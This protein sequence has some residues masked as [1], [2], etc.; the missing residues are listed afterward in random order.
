M[1]F[2]LID[3]G[4]YQVSWRG[5][6]K[7]AYDYVL[8]IHSDGG[9][10]FMPELRFRGFAY[11]L[12]EYVLVSHQ[13]ITMTADR[14]GFL[15]SQLSESIKAQATRDNIDVGI[16]VNHR[17]NNYPERGFIGS[18]IIEYYNPNNDQDHITLVVY[19]GGNSDRFGVL[20]IVVTDD[21]DQR[22][23][24][25]VDYANE[26]ISTNSNTL[27]NIGEAPVEFQPEPI[28]GE[29]DELIDS[30]QEIEIKTSLEPVQL[31]LIGDNKI[32]LRVDNI[33]QDDVY[34][35]R[36]ILMRRIDGDANLEW[37]F[38]TITD[39]DYDSEAFDFEYGSL[40]VGTYQIM[41]YALDSD[42]RPHKS[43]SIIWNYG[44]PD[45]S[46]PVDYTDVTGTDLPIK[47]LDNFL[48]DRTKIEGFSILFGHP[49]LGVNSP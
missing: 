31:D 35:D 4:T 32:R 39:L 16:R 34:K 41:Q 25:M 5:R 46:S 1:P 42:N 2:T 27:R 22:W 47:D 29:S 40:E 38:I 6:S 26:L 13:P 18:V 3:R 20:D 30:M 17:T 9:I 11:E 43:P 37:G 10:F 45:T 7:E 15:G 19:L 33:P 36:K 8:R 48:L 14:V 44:S 23:I 28:E 21:V 24:K 12:N 49:N